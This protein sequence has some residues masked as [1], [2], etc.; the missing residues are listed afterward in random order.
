MPNAADEAQAG[1]VAERIASD[2]TEH[3]RSRPSCSTVC[4]GATTLHASSGAAG[5]LQ[6]SGSKILDRNDLKLSHFRIKPQSAGTFV[7][8]IIIS[9]RS[10]GF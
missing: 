5:S 6:D 1:Q 8:R 7:P 3:R 10:G 4:G 2:F 9:G